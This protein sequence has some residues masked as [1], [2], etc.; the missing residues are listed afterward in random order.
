MAK[1]PL[2]IPQEG[3]GPPHP[4]RMYGFHKFGPPTPHPHPSVG[5]LPRGGL[6]YVWGPRCGCI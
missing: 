5:T 4:R 1:F 6:A 2:G 3:H